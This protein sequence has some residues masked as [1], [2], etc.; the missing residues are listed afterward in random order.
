MP[1]KYDNDRQYRK[2]AL[3]SLIA[4]KQAKSSYINRANPAI[5]AGQTKAITPPQIRVTH[6]VN[7][8]WI[9]KSIQA[10]LGSQSR[11]D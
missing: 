2:P 9:E 1:E 6:Q 5:S 3:K 11:L 4:L 10:I 8:D 7:P